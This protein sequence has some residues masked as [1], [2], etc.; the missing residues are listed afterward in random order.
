MIN[1]NDYKE[2]MNRIKE[3]QGTAWEFMCYHE[4]RVY[5]FDAVKTKELAA[6]L[7]DAFLETSASDFSLTE[8]GEYLAKHWDKITSY[9]IYPDALYDLYNGIQELNDF[10]RKEEAI[11]ITKPGLDDKIQ[12][13]KPEYSHSA[14]RI[15]KTIDKNICL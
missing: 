10:N 8:A 11:L 1:E 14:A 4:M 15:D 2:I 13:A 12:S 6:F 3:V 7:Y 5:S 9:D